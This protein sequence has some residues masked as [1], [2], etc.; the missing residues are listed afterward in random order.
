MN[1]KLAALADFASVSQDNKLNIL[2]IFQEVN[3][4]T[5][6][7]TVPHMYLVV[8]FEAES[9]DY[10]KQL[11][12]RVALVSKDSDGDE[13]L[14]L[15]GL[16]EVPQPTQPENQVY[17]NQVI[18]LAGVTFEHTGNYSFSISVEKEEKVVVPLRVNKL[19]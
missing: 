14:A 15:E 11:L 5:L 17:V 18:G 10:G 6:P 4:P 8:S 16:A 12:I 9:A 1:V 19:K 7:V 2:G 13:M 3:T